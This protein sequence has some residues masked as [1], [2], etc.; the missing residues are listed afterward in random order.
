MK[1]HH[2]Y[3]PHVAPL[4]CISEC[5]RDPTTFSVLLCIPDRLAAT[6]TLTKL[7][8][9]GHDDLNLVQAVQT[10]IFHKVGGCLQLW[11][12][13][14]CWHWK[15]HFSHYDLEINRVN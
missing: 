5:H 6:Q 11:S 13:M 7:I 9:H 15:S 3:I 12:R 8:L 4:C 14:T 10:Q 2:T 1:V